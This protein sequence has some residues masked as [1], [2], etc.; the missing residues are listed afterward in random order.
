MLD[1]ALGAVI[2][3]LAIRGWWRGLLREAIA[4]GVMVAGLILSFRLSTPVG[5]V[6]ESVA[7]VSPEAGRLI[8]GVVIFVAISVGAGIASAILHKGLRFVPGVPT[9]NR[10]AG[11]GFSVVATIA[12]ATLVLSLLALVSPPDAVARQI[13]G[14]ALAG[15]LTDPDKT[16]QKVMGFMSGDRVLERLL[17]LRELTGTRRLVGDGEA[18]TLDSIPRA[19]IDVDVAAEAGV[20]EMLNRERDAAGVDLVVA[21]EPLAEVARGYAVDVYTSGHFSN[22]SRDGITV[23]ERL[24]AADIPV[25]AADQVI[26]LAVTAEAAQE[27]LFGDE[28]QASVLTGADFRRVGI[29]IAKGPLGVVLVEVLAG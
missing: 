6:V 20:L 19:D 13:D 11:A 23:T 8:A 4:L 18:V 26:S 7:G 9:L 29:G 14:S 3:A 24:A 16:P 21:S 1:F 22:E 10:A 2:V 28:Q 27:A 25:V 15:Y 17:S 12:V 5:D